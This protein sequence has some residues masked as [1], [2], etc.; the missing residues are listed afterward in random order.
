MLPRLRVRGPGC[1]ALLAVQLAILLLS[2]RHMSRRDVQ[3]APPTA[4]AHGA[5]DAAAGDAQTRSTLPAATWPATSDLSEWVQLP[6]AYIFR[7][8]QSQ[9]LLHPDGA[10]LGVTAAAA[11][12]WRLLED[13]RASRQLCFFAHAQASTQDLPHPLLLSSP[14]AGWSCQRGTT[15]PAARPFCGTQVPCRTEPP[16]ARTATPTKRRRCAAAC[17]CLRGGAAM[18]STQGRGG[19]RRWR[20]T[21]GTAASDYRWEVVSGDVVI[22]VFSGR[23]KG[24]DPRLEPLFCAPEIACLVEAIS[25]PGFHLLLATMAPSGLP[26]PGS[27]TSALDWTKRTPLTLPPRPCPCRTCPPASS[28]PAFEAARCG[29]WATARRGESWGTGSAER[30]LQNCA[31]TCGH[32]LA[33][34]PHM[35]RLATLLAPQLNDPLLADA[36]CIHPSQAL[37]LLSRVLPAGVCAQPAP[38]VSH[39]PPGFGSDC[40]QHCRH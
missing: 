29:S 7:A 35:S 23:M 4:R 25:S 31:R 22:H 11:P 30:Q 34:A 28:L 33:A 37:L 38:H 14:Q 16:P 19:R 8:P 5:D 36:V 10:A 40:M 2:I 17:A 1:G 24:A 27:C 3:Q 39:P 15:A 32:V 21:C 9:C 20:S 12:C 18:P 6:Y 13:G 26:C